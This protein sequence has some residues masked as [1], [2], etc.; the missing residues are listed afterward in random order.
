MKHILIVL[1]TL[2]LLSIPRTFAAEYN[3]VNIDGEIYECTAYSYDTSK[4]YQVQVEFEGDEV[5]IFFPKGGHI[6][7]TL[8]DEEIDDP[9]SISAY[10][11]KTSTYWDLDVDGLD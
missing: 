6:V 11:Y 8:D 4:F 7:L 3:G 10:Y 9:S 1:L 2:C 5:T